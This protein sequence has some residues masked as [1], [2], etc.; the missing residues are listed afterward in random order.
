MG[1]RLVV[2]VFL[3]VVDYT[4]LKE[5]TFGFVGFEFG[6]GWVEWGLLGISRYF[7]AVKGCCGLYWVVRI[8]I[9]CNGG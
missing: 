7:K 4:R 6:F 2:M 3:V 9:G 1:F 8:L 5:E